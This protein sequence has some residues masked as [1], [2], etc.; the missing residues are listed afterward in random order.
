MFG[1]DIHESWIGL[2]CL[3]H[4]KRIAKQERIAERIGN[5]LRFL[6]RPG[7]RLR[8]HLIGIPSDIAVKGILGESTLIAFQSRFF[9]NFALT[10]LCVSYHER[11]AYEPWPHS[12]SN[13][14][15]SVGYGGIWLFL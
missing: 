7:Q 9:W 15:V 13:R 4:T 10:A 3:P 14:S 2:G 1:Q 5:V 8:N 6:Q 11:L 12:F